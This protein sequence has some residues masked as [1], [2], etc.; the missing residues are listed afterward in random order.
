MQSNNENGKSLL[1]ELKQLRVDMAKY[2]NQGQAQ[3]EAIINNSNSAAGATTAA[4]EKIST[5][6]QFVPVAA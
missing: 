3:V 1:A 5:K 6:G 4:V 2:N